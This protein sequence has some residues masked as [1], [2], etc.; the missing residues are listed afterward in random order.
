VNLSGIAGGDQAA[1]LVALTRVAEVRA[2]AIARPALVLKVEIE[3]LGDPAF[4][5]QQITPPG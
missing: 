5:I 3:V 2:A 1:P 4:G